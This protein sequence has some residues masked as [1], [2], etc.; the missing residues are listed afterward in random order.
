[1]AQLVQLALIAAAVLTALYLIIRA[2]DRRQ[3]QTAL[4]A[5]PIAG[6][7]DVE[8]AAALAHAAADYVVKDDQRATA[9]V[10]A[11]A[12]AVEFG[13]N[14]WMGGAGNEKSRRAYSNAQMMLRKA[15]E[16][17]D[18]N[19]HIAAQQ[20]ARLGQELLKAAYMAHG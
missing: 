1:M 13:K 12:V 3:Q 19:E 18:A 17:L 6:S 20:F 16:K 2:S 14:D 4:M 5:L 10:G 7:R 9:M 8:F 11:L 15:Q